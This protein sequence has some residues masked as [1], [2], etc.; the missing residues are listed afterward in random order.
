MKIGIRKKTVLGL[1]LAAGLQLALADVLIPAGG[2]IALGGGRLDNVGNLS[3]AGTLDA[4]TGGISLAG[5]WTRT[6]TFV[7]GTSTVSFIDGGL[8]QSNLTGDTDFHALSLV[9]STG[10]TYVIESSRTLRVAAG[11]TIRGLAGSPIQVASPDPSRVAFVNLAAAGTQDIEFVGVSNVHAS[12]QPLAPTQSNQGG[13][14]NARGW[15]GSLLMAPFPVPGLSP[16]ALLVLGLLMIATAMRRAR[17]SRTF[18]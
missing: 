1:L 2:S 8:G 9:S 10:K 16:L 4:G 12:G 11:L 17:R 15:F 14:G 6:G 13:T 5:D 7:P 3:I 18:E